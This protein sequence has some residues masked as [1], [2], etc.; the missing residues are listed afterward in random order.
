MFNKFIL[1]V[2]FTLAIGY[3]QTRHD[4][5]QPSFTFWTYPTN[6]PPV[7]PTG[8]EFLLTFPGG[9][10]AKVAGSER[11][12]VCRNYSTLAYSHYNY[13]APNWQ[14][15]VTGPVGDNDTMYYLSTQPVSSV[16][17]LTFNASFT[18]VL[19]SDSSPSTNAFVQS[20]FFVQDYCY[21]FGFYRVLQN[22]GDSMEESTVIFY[23]AQNSNCYNVGPLGSC[24]DKQ[25]GISVQSNITTQ[26]FTN[27]GAN[28]RSGTNWIYS[29]NLISPGQWQITV[30]DP[31]NG[32]AGVTPFTVPVQ[33]YFQNTAQLL[34]NSGLPGYLTATQESAANVGTITDGSPPLK[35]TVYSI[36]ILNNRR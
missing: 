19:G 25:T 30:T 33:S 4:F 12:P 3:A 11:P 2:G 10:G 1:A 20:I 15:P 6:S 16:K 27:P 23:Y 36:G 26:S 5:S 34:F 8:A 7:P 32:A 24:R 21:E 29:A 9:N 17:G 35:L 14:G 18:G 28:S 13:V 22:P 31:Y